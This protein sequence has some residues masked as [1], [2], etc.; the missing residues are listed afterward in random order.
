METRIEEQTHIHQI[1]R[2]RKIVLCLAVFIIKDTQCELQ[3]TI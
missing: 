3:P 2:V 1:P